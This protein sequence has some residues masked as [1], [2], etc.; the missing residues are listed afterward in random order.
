MADSLRATPATAPASSLV[1]W[2]DLTLRER[3]RFSALEASPFARARARF[4]RDRFGVR[5]LIVWTKGVASRALASPDAA[6]AFVDGPR[7]FA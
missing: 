3:E 1:D 4:V 5:P 7:P 2:H 6:A